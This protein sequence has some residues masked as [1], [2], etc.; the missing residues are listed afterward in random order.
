MNRTL[1]PSLPSHLT[2]EQTDTCHKNSNHRNICGGGG[3]GRVI[4]NG[5]M[6]FMQM[7]AIPQPNY[8]P[9]N[10]VG[11]KRKK[12]GVGILESDENDSQVVVGILR[13]ARAVKK[14]WF[15]VGCSPMCISGI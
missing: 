2:N 13:V 8:Y 9:K 6:S 7:K 11:K 12:R 3:G 14:M 1:I 5:L 15:V 10:L 4:T